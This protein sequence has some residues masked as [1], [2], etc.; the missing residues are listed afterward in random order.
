[1]ISWE[2]F[3]GFVVVMMTSVIR[4]LSVLNFELFL[5]LKPTCYV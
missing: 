5:F 4:K 2:L 1:M 3:L